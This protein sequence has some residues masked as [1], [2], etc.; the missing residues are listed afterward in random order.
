V[1]YP[2]NEPMIQSK[3][4]FRHKNQTTARIGALPNNKGKK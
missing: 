3:I 2:Y 4:E 1:L